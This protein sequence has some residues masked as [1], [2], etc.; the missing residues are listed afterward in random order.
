MSEAGA[1]TITNKSG[2]T[3]SH[4]ST[5]AWDAFSA[6]KAGDGFQV[7]LEGTGTRND[8]FYVW[9]TNADGVITKGSGWKSADAATGLGWEDTFSSDTNGD[10]IIGGGIRDDDLNGLVDDVT[11]YQMVSE[12]GAVT[13]KNSNGGTYSD[14]S[15]G[16]WDARAAAQVDSGFRVL[17][18][19]TVDSYRDQYIVWS[20][21]FNGTINDSTGWKTGGELADLGM[22]ALF[23]VDLNAD[24]M[25]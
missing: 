1:V 14:A 13:L 8:Q 6:V 22:E 12:V 19:G 4:N 18:E 23:R 24:G 21:D 20:T 7:L 16:K 25:I 11:N 15:S 5:G 3:Y 17:L 9:T 2:K 10:G